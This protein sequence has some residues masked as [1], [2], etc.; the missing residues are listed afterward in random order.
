MAGNSIL[1]NKPEIFSEH[2]GERI[3]HLGAMTYKLPGN[4]DYEVFQVDKAHVARP[5]LIADIFYG[6]AQYGD[7]ICKINNIPNPFELNEGM[8][9]IVPTVASLDKFYVQD[10]FNDST[11]EENGK[12]K[13]P[14]P[15]TRTEKRKP[16]EAVVGD[17][18][19]KIDKAN[20]VIIY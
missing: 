17:T 8:F 14:R 5:D 18:R 9:I 2:L 16:N 6:D 15:K 3:I 20:R 4:I 19:F 12:T 13:R 7:L 1:Q 11:S 10:I